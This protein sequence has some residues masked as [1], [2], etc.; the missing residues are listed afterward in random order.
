ME[1]HLASVHDTNE[2]H[3]FSHIHIDLNNQH[4]H[5]FILQ[6][7]NVHGGKEQQQSMLAKYRSHF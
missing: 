1:K 5:V 6:S 4:S 7:P 2:L 3:M